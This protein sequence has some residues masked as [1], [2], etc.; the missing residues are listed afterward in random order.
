[1]LGGV[2][3]GIADAVGVE[4]F[5]VRIGF[6]ALTVLG[7]SGPLLY[8]L[9]WI[10]MP[11]RGRRRSLAERW[12]HQRNQQSWVPIVAVAAAAMLL[13][14]GIGPWEPQGLLAVALVALG[15]A[16]F[17]KQLVD[18]PRP[19]APFPPPPPATEA[20]AS[21]P[22][23]AGDASYAGSYARF[24]ADAGPRP[25]DS[26]AYAYPYAAPWPPR[27]APPPKPARPPSHLGRLTFGTL[28]LALAL[29][30]ILD[31]IGLVTL[32]APGGLAIALAVL[33][34]GMVLGAW[35]GRGR[36]LILPTVLVA[37]ALVAAN[38]INAS[39]ANVDLAAFT[40]GGG[41]GERDYRPQTLAEVGERYQLLLGELQLDL[42][43]VAFTPTPTEVEVVVGVGQVI[44][45][46]PEDATVRVEGGVTVGH[47]EIFGEEQE[48]PGFALDG[49]RAGEEGGG[50]LHLDLTIGAGEV[51]IREAP[52]AAADRAGTPPDGPETPE[53]PAGTTR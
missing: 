29:A 20:E 48:G 42:S 34:A 16:L 30:A 21:A 33:G 18:Q 39:L 47:S 41:I 25:G 8:A 52:A 27:H 46:V 10:L 14:A 37:F 9:G 44:V 31:A 49:E 53:P 45:T 15:V 40:T 35:W 4:P 24:S 12:W 11:E 2:A 43:D 23:P 6:V 13:F 22:P 3:S 5:L 50:V 1:M 51:V 19:A 36:G 28:L 7:G 17:R 32:T 38:G 26:S